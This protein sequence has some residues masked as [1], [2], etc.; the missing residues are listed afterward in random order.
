MRENVEL[1]PGCFFNDVLPGSWGSDNETAAFIHVDC[2]VYASTKSV[3]THF[4]DHIRP[5]TVI[6]FDEYFNYPGWRNHEFRAFREFVAARNVR[7][8]YLGYVRVGHS[9]AVL[10]Q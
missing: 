2:D 5:G 1:H 3:F 9:V 6:Q 10:I 4:A 7:Y 8:Q